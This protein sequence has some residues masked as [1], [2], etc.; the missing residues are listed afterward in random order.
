LEWLLNL[1]IV[2]LISL[3]LWILVCFWFHQLKNLKTI[4]V[5]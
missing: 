1:Q 2:Y 4:Q 5:L 3:G